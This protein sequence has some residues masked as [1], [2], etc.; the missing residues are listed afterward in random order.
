MGS[1]DNRGSGR[2]VDDWG[3][4]DGGVEG[5][6]MT[7]EQAAAIARRIGMTHDRTS[8][9]DGE[10]VCEEI[11]LPTYLATGDRPLR[12]MGAYRMFVDVN[13]TAVLA[14]AAAIEG[15]GHE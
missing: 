6:V 4:C 12:V 5:D 11:H 3:F 7:P 1:L 9:F 8:W 14:C 15:E 10:Y 13:P 2:H